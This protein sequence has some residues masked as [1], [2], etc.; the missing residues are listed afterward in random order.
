MNSN[1]ESLKT[2][3]SQSGRGIYQTLV[4]IECLSAQDV[5]ASLRRFQ[6]LSKPRNALPPK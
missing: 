3:R 4:Y 1:T 2:F 6:T 5:E